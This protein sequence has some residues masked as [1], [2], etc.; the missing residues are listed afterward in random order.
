MVTPPKKIDNI[1]SWNWN[2]IWDFFHYKNKL[3]SLEKQIKETNRTYV[4]GK[5]DKETKKKLHNFVRDAYTILIN[6]LWYKINSFK[7]RVEIQILNN[8]IKTKKLLRE[9]QNEI[10]ATHNAKE[11]EKNRIELESKTQTPNKP[12]NPNTPI[13]KNTTEIKKDDPT[14]LEKIQKNR[15]LAWEKVEQYMSTVSQKTSGP[16]RAMIWWLA[17]KAK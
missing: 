2:Y 14:L 9:L 4:E 13:K 15:I 7:T 8:E 12:K 10:L 5:E 1:E 11:K 16:L 17:Q 6:R 3:S